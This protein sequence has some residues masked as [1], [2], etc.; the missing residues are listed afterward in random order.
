MYLNL[1]T[2]FILLLVIMNYSKGKP[3]MKLSTL[4]RFIERQCDLG[5][6]ESSVRSKN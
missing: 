5:K 6:K 1:P 4:H 3:V 2:Y